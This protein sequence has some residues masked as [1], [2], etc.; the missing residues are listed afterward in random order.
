ME[1]TKQQTQKIANLSI[2][3]T[4]ELISNSPTTL[5]AAIRKF[6]EETIKMNEILFKKLKIVKY[7]TSYRWKYV[8]AIVDGI[9]LNTIKVISKNWLKYTKLYKIL[10][11]G[12]DLDL[13]DIN[14]WST[15]EEPKCVRLKF[16]INETILFCDVRISDKD[17][18]NDINDRFEATL[19][20]PNDFIT[21]IK[22][23]IEWAINDYA[24]ECY[25]EFLEAE[26]EKWINEFIQKTI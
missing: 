13:S 15:Y 14:T 20:L 5:N 2:D 24:E 12:Y 10:P 17:Y 23:D 18:Y 4:L 8:C 22:D 11:E 7:I 1:L 9:K 26:K 25:E 3:Q 19:Q 21:I 6:G 16:Y